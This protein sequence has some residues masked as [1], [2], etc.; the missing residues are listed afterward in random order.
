MTRIVDP[1]A[2]G[3]REALAP[4]LYITATPIGNRGDVTLR[5]L[6]VL[7][8]AD[9]LLCEDTRVTRKLLGLYGLSRPLTAYH[10]H[11]AESMRPKILEW[12]AAGQSVALVSDAG[13]P[14]I[15]D[16]GFKLARD[17][18]AA[19]LTVTALPGASAVLTALAVAG[20][21]TDRFLFLGFLPP[22]SAARRTELAE[23]AA[24]RATLVIYESPRRLAALLADAAAV[25]PGRRAVVCRELTKL[26]EET[27][28][29]TSDDL[30]RRYAEAGP[31][32]GEV[33]VVFGPPDPA[34][35]AWDAAELDAALRRALETK[36]VKDAAAEVAAAAGRPR[37]ELYARAMR[38]R[39]AEER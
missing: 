9:R 39:E 25:L 2:E 34:R 11:N 35:S 37:Q 18:R 4:A 8:R 15:S 33:V 12:I 19:G 13:T 38:L 17:C 36:S 23:V 22:K 32:K 7:A 1:P 26:F 3:L 14:L 21:P 24:V 28:D 29:G 5:A 31:P 30:A 10:D 20:L 27:V 16:P 6:E